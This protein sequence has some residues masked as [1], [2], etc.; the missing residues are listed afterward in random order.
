MISDYDRVVRRM[1]RAGIPCAFRVWDPAIGNRDLLFRL[2]AAARANRSVWV[3]GPAGSGKSRAMGALAVAY[4]A[5]RFG[6]RWINCSNLPAVQ[7]C[8]ACA[9]SLRVTPILIVDAFDP[10]AIPEPWREVLGQ[11]LPDRIAARYPT[12]VASRLLPTAIFAAKAAHV[13]AYL[14]TEP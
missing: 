12:W 7:P 11:V 6:A 1:E 10:K 8:A 14:E 2:E 9:N 4:L 13:P 5:K 3:S